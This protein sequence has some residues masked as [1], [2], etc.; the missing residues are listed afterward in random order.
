MEEGFFCY[1]Q[2]CR[3]CTHGPASQRSPWEP[4]LSRWARK[5]A[6]LHSVSNGNLPSEATFAIHAANELGDRGGEAPPSPVSP[7]FHAP[8]VEFNEKRNAMGTG[9]SGRENVESG[10]LEMAWVLCTCGKIALMS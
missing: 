2:R 10:L 8:H 9:P 3:V 6:P 5:F 1:V 4:W 7:L